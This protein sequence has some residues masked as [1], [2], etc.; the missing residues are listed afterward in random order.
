[1]YRQA[2]FVSTLTIPSPSIGKWSEPPPAP[3]NTADEDSVLSGATSR[4]FTQG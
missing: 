3:D 1:M 4:V 2:R